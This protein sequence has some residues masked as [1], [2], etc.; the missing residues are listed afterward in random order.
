MQETLGFS[1]KLE[2]IERILYAKNTVRIRV[3]LTYIS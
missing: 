2:E 3:K 1:G